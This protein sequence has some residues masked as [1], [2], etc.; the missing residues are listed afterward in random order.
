VHRHQQDHALVTPSAADLEALAQRER[1]QKELNAI[2]FHDGS[3]RILRSSGWPPQAQPSHIG[4][5]GR[6][7]NPSTCG[8]E[9]FN[10]LAHGKAPFQGECRTL[11][12]HDAHV[13]GNGH[14]HS[15]SALNTALDAGLY[16]STPH[17]DWRHRLDPG[18]KLCTLACNF[19]Q[20]GQLS[21]RCRH[22]TAV[23]V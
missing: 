18:P 23:V 13:S 1:H 20:G 3:F 17:L 5:I 21:D 19:N 2:D 7:I 11:L 14:T 9:G 8:H 10:G 12:A 15:P 22:R 4:V 16:A 6:G